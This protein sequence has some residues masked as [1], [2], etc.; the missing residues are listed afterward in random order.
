MYNAFLNIPLELRVFYL[1]NMS[2]LNT[3]HFRALRFFFLNV[4][5]KLRVFYLCNM[6]WLTTSHFR[7]LRHIAQYN[8][9]LNVS[10]ILRFFFI[11]VACR[12]LLAFVLFML[13]SERTDTM[14][15]LSKSLDILY[16]AFLNLFLKLRFFI[17]VPCPDWTHY[18][19]ES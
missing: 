14:F 5:L 19:S 17:C 11:C 7:I 2:W 18:I 8:A 1:C 15:S 6:S 13:T 3:L 9:F 16:N 10:L 12:N 4:S